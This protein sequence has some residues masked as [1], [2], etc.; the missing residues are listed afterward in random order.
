MAPAGALQVLC[1]GTGLVDGATKP[2]LSSPFQ[3]SVLT[4]TDANGWWQRRQCTFRRRRHRVVF[5]AI[6]PGAAPVWGPRTRLLA[7]HANAWKACH[8]THHVNQAQQDD[9]VE[10]EF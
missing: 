9:R 3:N 2:D 5:P 4:R 6:L 8:H 7:F 1:K 10:H